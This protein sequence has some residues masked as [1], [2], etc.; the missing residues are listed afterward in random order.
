MR[1]PWGRWKV[2]GESTSGIF[3]DQKCGF[4]ERMQPFSRGPFLVET[5]S[6]PPIFQPCPENAFIRVMTSIPSS[7]LPEPL[8]TPFFQLLFVN[9][10]TCDLGLP[11]SLHS[12]PFLFHRKQLEWISYLQSASSDLP[13]HG[14]RVRCPPPSIAGAITAIVKVPS[15]FTHPPAL[16]SSQPRKKPHLFFPAKPPA[17]FFVYSH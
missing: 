14:T 8:F 11:S 1:G 12:P 10:S 17:V 9:P 16:F 2:L 5:E 4:L 6:V 7:S 15:P 3:M 13:T